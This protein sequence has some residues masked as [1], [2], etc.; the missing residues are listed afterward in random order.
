M[1][2]DFNI[3]ENKSDVSLQFYASQF[4]VSHINLRNDIITGSTVEV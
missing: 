3:E 2:F 4:S 1:Q